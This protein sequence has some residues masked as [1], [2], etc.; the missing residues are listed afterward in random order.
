MTTSILPW[1]RVDPSARSVPK[2]SFGF[3]Q[4]QTMKQNTQGWECIENR[5]IKF[6]VLAESLRS[7]AL[8]VQ[9]PGRF[10]LAMSHYADD[11]TMAGVLWK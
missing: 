1:L 5:F 2:S 8:S 11:T 7:I 9:P 3:S 4:K 10:L 6:R